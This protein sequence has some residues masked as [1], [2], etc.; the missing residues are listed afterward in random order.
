MQ[1]VV[2]WIAVFALAVAE[3]PAAADLDGPR[4][5][6]ER[7]AR[8]LEAR[9]ASGLAALYHPDG[10]HRDLASGER[11][12]GVDSLR[13]LYATRLSTNGT[14]PVRIDSFR[15][16]TADV[17]IAQLTMSGTPSQAPSGAARRWPPFTAVVLSREDGRWGVAATR[18]G[19]NPNTPGSSLP[20]EP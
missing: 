13:N 3:G 15:L 18:A 19:G 1:R 6:V 16:L 8:L 20:L 14:G 7:F 17:A 2:S 10:G 11:I 9:D 5:V 12:R 4:A